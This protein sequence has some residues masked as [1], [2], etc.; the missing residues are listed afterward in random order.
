M[1]NHKCRCCGV[2]EPYWSGIYAGKCNP[3]YNDRNGDCCRRRRLSERKI[4][5]GENAEMS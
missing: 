1:A 4:V 3:C 2:P 5:Y